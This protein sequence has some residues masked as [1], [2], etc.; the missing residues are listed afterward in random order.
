MRGGGD[1]AAPAA[2]PVAELV[3]AHL[4]DDHAWRAHEGIPV[5]LRKAT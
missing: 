1:G 5:H 2:S 4:R 3:L